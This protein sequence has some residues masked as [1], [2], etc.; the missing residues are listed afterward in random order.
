MKDAYSFH[1]SEESLD[2]EYKN[3]AEAYKKIFNR[4]GLETR[5][6]CNQIQEP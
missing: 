5:M 1:T 2:E 4:C 6:N 3:M